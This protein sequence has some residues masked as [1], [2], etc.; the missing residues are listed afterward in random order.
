MF[1]QVSCQGRRRAGSYLRSV[2]ELYVASSVAGQY[3]DP[4]K[5][6]NRVVYPFRKVKINLNFFN[7]HKSVRVHVDALRID[8]DY[9][10]TF[11]K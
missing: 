2:A 3:E 10:R 8:C 9:Q 6:I 7:K 4:I 11:G 5:A 1:L